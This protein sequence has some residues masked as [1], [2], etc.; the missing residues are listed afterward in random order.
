VAV[1]WTELAKEAP[2]H[3]QRCACFTVQS[4][5]FRLDKPIGATPLMIFNV[6]VSS[7]LG[8]SPGHEYGADPGLAPKRLERYPCKTRKVNP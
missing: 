7:R 6:C 1:G 8:A 3:S 4:F 5:L 2:G